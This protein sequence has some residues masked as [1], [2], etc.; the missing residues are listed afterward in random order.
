VTAVPGPYL[1]PETGDVLNFRELAELERLM[2]ERPGTAVAKRFP[3]YTGPV[4]DEMVSL[5]RLEP[6]AA[7]AV[8]EAIPRVPMIPA[9]P[10]NRTPD[11]RTAPL[12]GP[13]QAAGDRRRRD[14]RVG[15]DGTAAL[16][17]GQGPA[18]P[19]ALS[20]SRSG[21]GAAL[22]ATAL[23]AGCAAWGA[24]HALAAR[25]VTAGGGTGLAELYAITFLALAW[26]VI[27]YAIDRPFRSRRP[28]VPVNVTI[29]VPCY[30]ED[31]A[32]LRASLLSMTAQD[33]L[34]DHVY[35]V[36]DG[37]TAADYRAV[38]LEAA[39]AMAAA[40][41]RF[42]WAR[43]PNG[44]KRQAHA[45]AV[46]AT[47]DAGVYVTV[48]SD[49]ILDRRAVGELL[50]PFAD[51]RVRS[52]AGVFLASNNAATL[53][54]RVLDLVYLP[55][56]LLGRGGMSVMGSVL[57]NSGALAAYRAD[58][59]REALPAYLGETFAGRPVG[60]S[61]DSFLTLQA[62]LKGRT[63]HQASAF[64]FAAMPEK[65][66]HHRRQYLRWMRG[67]FIRSW[68]RFRYL[69]LLS[70]AYWWHLAG[71]V[72]SAVSTWALADAVVLGALHGELRWP[73]LLVPAVAGYG[74][75]LP[76]LTVR[77]SDETLASRLLTWSLAPVAVLWA[78]TVLRAFRWWGAL[79]CLE[80]GWGTRQKIEVKL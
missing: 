59:V 68:W 71:W 39:A 45:V 8:T 13:A 78:F 1:G 72:L 42:S 37:S 69:P 35:V 11:A 50:A 3:P 33:R 70:Y 44:G 53:L 58:V 67:S 17:E 25:A 74:L 5:A 22:A 73:Y 30:N 23:L 31:P 51:S 7:R 9:I 76:Y 15:R 62:F 65:F 80:T 38:R 46:R 43:T 41:V 66:S 27:L 6:A 4:T 2:L 55:S 19:V 48:D 47:P 36:D 54:A 24:R 52:V 60:F 64:A 29:A 49:S 26:Q 18:G 16:E 56:Q 63:V 61:D 20:A 14:R 12:P 10:T 34:P 77:R 75:A 57:V 32:I 79:T 28:A 40:G 21:A